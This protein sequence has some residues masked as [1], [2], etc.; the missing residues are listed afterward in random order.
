MN[1]PTLFTLSLLFTLISLQTAGDEP[2]SIVV[3]SV[4]ADSAVIAPVAWYRQDDGQG[5]AYQVGVSGWT[6]QGEWSR[7]RSERHSLL[8]SA[9]VTPMNAHNSNRTFEDGERTEQLDYE[10]ASYRMRGGVRLHANQSSNI[11]I[12]LVG[13]YESVDGLPADV[14]Q[15]WESPYAGLEVAYTYREVREEQPLIASIDGVE[16]TTRGE[17]FVGEDNWSRITVSQQWGNTIGRFHLRQGASAVFSTGDDFVNASLIGGSWDALG[18]RA[19]Y[20]LRHGEIRTGHAF[21]GSVGADVRVTR[22]WFVGAR[23]SAIIA[24]DLIHGFAFNVSG[25]WR[26]FGFNG[27]VALAES[28][29]HRT[30]VPQVYAAVVVPLYRR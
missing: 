26:T 7:R 12:L 13:L 16:V 1:R 14:M 28:W 30:T 22:H 6:V 20:G 2:A 5:T 9:D 17:G 11:D 25:T 29:G 27:G 18:G 24:E 4:Y 23:T 21:V 3:S 19:A 10:H 8:F 15:R